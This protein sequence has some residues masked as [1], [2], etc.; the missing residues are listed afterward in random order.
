MK[1]TGAG[2]GQQSENVLNVVQIILNSDVFENNTT[3]D[4]LNRTV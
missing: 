1:K 3:S 2:I 4:W